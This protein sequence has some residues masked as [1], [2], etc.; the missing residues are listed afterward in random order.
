MRKAE[1]YLLRLV[2]TAGFF[3]LRF[4]PCCRDIRECVARAL[5]P[6]RCRSAFEGAA[7][8]ADSSRALGSGLALGALK[9]DTC[10]L[11][12]LVAVVGTDRKQIALLRIL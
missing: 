6:A 5:K 7:V 2:D 9:E 8:F 12:D 1:L 11:F 3:K 10:D 4:E